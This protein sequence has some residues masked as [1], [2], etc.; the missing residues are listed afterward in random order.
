MSHR[1]YIMFYHTTAC[2]QKK[3][4]LL[5]LCQFVHLQSNL[6][7]P[8]NIPSS[9]KYIPWTKT[10]NLPF[11]I[12]CSDGWCCIISSGSTFISMFAKSSPFSQILSASLY[13]SSDRNSCLISA[14]AAF[15]WIE[16]LMDLSTCIG[17]GHILSIFCSWGNLQIK[18][19][20]QECHDKFTV[21]CVIL[22]NLN[23]L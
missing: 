10:I 3:K 6:P 17:L 4:T 11:T 15:P 21:L 7:L 13:S 18:V 23:S 14:S 22:K 2:R 12:N 16:L 8:P 9:I 19:I 5:L 1:Y 20:E